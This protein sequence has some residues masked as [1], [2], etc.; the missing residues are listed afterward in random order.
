MLVRHVRIPVQPS[1]KWGAAVLVFSAATHLLACLARVNFVSGLALI[2]ILTGLVLFFWGAAALRRLWFPLAFLV[3]MVPLPEVTIS[4]MN[5]RLKMFAADGGVQLANL[6]G[7]SAIRAGNR[8]FLEDGKSLVIANVCNGLRTLISLLAFGAMYAYICRLRGLWRL[9][10]LALSIPIAVACNSLRIVT[11]ILVADIWDEKVACGWYHDL[12]G[13]LIYPLAFAMM[14]G[15]ERLILWLRR[16]AGRPAAISP[17]F[18][19]QALGPEEG[20]Q[21]SVLAGALGGPRGWSMVVAVVLLAAAAGWVNRSVQPIWNQSIARAA[22]PVNLTVDGRQWQG[23]DLQMDENSLTILE[24]RDY[25][26]R[27]YFSPNCLPVDFTIIFSKDNRKGTHPPDLCLEGS[28]EGIVGKR[29]V[30][31]DGIPG[32]GQV[33]CAELIVQSGPDR[34]CFLYTYKCGGQYTNSF[35]RQQFLIC[36]NGL[37]GANASGALI[38]VSVPVAGNNLDMARQRNIEFM[39]AAIPYLDKNL[40]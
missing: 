15:V 9:T 17:K 5:F 35:W 26:Y 31:V 30:V 33:R 23:Y 28:G 27:K 32:R 2:G 21:W 4:Q 38:R 40:N 37:I 29:D 25:L 14:F 6:L 3:F 24:T 12:S 34:Q 36:V 1:R 22:M 39:R 19:G 10:L 18:E 16:R 13:F 20:G 7:I 8:V 11:L